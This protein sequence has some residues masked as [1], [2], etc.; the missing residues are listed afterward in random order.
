MACPS[1][2]LRSLSLPAL[3]LSACGLACQPL[4]PA[5]GGKRVAPTGKTVHENPKVSGFD[6]VHA[7][8]SFQVQIER[9]SST[10]VEIV[11]DEAYAKYVV[12]DVDDG[13]LDIGLDGKVRAKNAE[14]RA[15]VTMPTL[16]GL[17][18]SG[19]S[20]ITSKVEVSG[21]GE[22]Q[23][24]GASTIKAPASADEI[25]L[26]ASG[27]STIKLSGKTDSMSAKASGASTLTLGDLTIDEL[28][29][30]LSG[31]SRFEADA[32]TVSAAMTGASRGTLTGTTKL[33]SVSLAGASHLTYPSG[34][35]VGDK[36]IGGGSQLVGR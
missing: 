28:Q 8:G 20:W 17:D 21:D 4:V 19:A 5:G 27:A 26:K 24:S 11:V 13:V 3:W 32:T 22:V 36:R 25:E 9:G 23:A 16:H 14:F 18:A 1:D 29:L 6:A 33:D 35:S 2:F 7:S 10:S 15:I 34:A 30:Q 31:A 12:V